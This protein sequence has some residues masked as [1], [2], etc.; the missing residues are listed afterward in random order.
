M[1]VLRAVGGPLTIF[2][3]KARQCR[4]VLTPQSVPSLLETGLG[5]NSYGALWGS[6]H[7]PSKAAA[8]HV[9][10]KETSP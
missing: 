2:Q 10:S 4:P 7:H 1:L 3:I 6:S 8:S 9:S 5:R